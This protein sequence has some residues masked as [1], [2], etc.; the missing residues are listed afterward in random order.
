LS[1]LNEEEKHMLPKLLR[2]Y[3]EDKEFDTLMEDVHEFVSQPNQE[4]GDI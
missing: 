1:F 2:R 4:V 3:G